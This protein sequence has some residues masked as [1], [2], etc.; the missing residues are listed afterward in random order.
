M[1]MNVHPLTSCLLDYHSASGSVAHSLGIDFVGQTV[2]IRSMARVDGDI[3]PDAQVNDLDYADI[4][5]PATDLAEALLKV[6]LGETWAR[7]QRTQ[8]EES[9]LTIG[10][11]TITFGSDSLYSPGPARANLDEPRQAL[12]LLDTHE[13]A[14]GNDLD[15]AR[16]G[17]RLPASQTDR[18]FLS[19][20]RQ[21]PDYLDR[22]KQVGFQRTVMGLLREA[23][24][25]YLRIEAISGHDDLWAV[26][27]GEPGR[28]TMLVAMR[29]GSEGT[30]DLQVVD[31]VNGVRDRRAATKAVIVTQS[32]FSST[33]TR[34]YGGLTERMELV[35][36]DRL[37]GM[38]LDTGW[39]SQEPGFLV[40]PLAERPR[41]STFISYSHK[42]RPFAVWL[43][44]R[45]QSWHYR[46]FLDQVDMIPGEVILPALQKAVSAADSILLCCSREALESRW[47]QQE[48]KF[49]IEREQKESRTLLIPLDIDDALEKSQGFPELRDRLRVD[50][51]AWT[52]TEPC[53]ASLRKV[54]QALDQRSRGLGAG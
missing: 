28:G 20:L 54:R 33:V 14:F 11:G 23:H 42:T 26:H 16:A 25:S 6:Q 4:E 10:R 43:Y 9:R 49:A 1:S 13:L 30:I 27:A 8:H 37:K 31:R 22:L 41:C 50:F 38:L 12:L 39:T 29:P 51:R 45:L 15:Q 3:G 32:F 24:S 44:N 19:A 7:Q 36:F 46:C 5:M 35:D 40:C 21:H 48:I 52:P 34:E 18:A 2:R 17:V 53:N 47:V